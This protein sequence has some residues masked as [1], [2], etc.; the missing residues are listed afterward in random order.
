MRQ[1][2]FLF[3]SLSFPLFGQQV[4][5]DWK[6]SRQSETVELQYRWVRIGDTLKTR[7]LR[8]IFDVNA[9][10]EAIL[11][12]LSNEKEFKVWSVGVKNCQS[13]E[14]TNDGWIMYSHFDIPKPFTQR[15]LIAR[16]RLEQH[17]SR[18]IIHVEALPEYLPHQKGVDRMKNYSGYWILDER[19]GN[20]TQVKFHS[21]SFTK[22]IFPRFIQDPIIQRMLLKSF[23]TLISLSENDAIAQN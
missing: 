22:P 4:L 21:T 18:T 13:I 20:Q 16:Y 6:T 1:L 7:E 2:I 5:T 9:P 10:M 3:C 19:E 12:N 11:Y 15:D 14:H 17:E 8:A 23:E